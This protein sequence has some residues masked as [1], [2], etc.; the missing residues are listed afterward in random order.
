M[1]NRISRRTFVQLVPLSA[2]STV[3]P[4]L[5]HANTWKPSRAVDLLISYSAGGGADT[6]ARYIMKAVQEKDELMFVPVNKAGAG[7]SIM[8]SALQAANP[9][10]YTIG[11]CLSLQLKALPDS[12]RPSFVISDFTPIA[13]LARAP[14]ALVAPSERPFSDLRSMAAYSQQEKR[15]INLGSSPDLA[16]VAPRVAA[17]LGIDI[18]SVPFKGGAEMLQSALGGHIDLYLSAG[19]H[20][21]LEKAGRLRV[22]AAVTSDR[23]PMTPNVATLKEQG[24]DAAVDARFIVMGP[25]DLA[26]DAAA[27]LSNAFAR[28]MADEDVRRHVTSD[29]NLIVDYLG[30][31]ELQQVVTASEA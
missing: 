20:V 23:L 18:V 24:V 1:D 8:L 5:T 19:S 26:A 14:M 28:A 9:D 2:L 3:F 12:G 29:L 15:P 25:K 27:V 17:V 10:G 11:M 21:S 30:P 4:A 16:W 22:V 7:G 31:G 13:G 6:L